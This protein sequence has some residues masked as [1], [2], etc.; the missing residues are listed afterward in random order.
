MPRC[1]FFLPDYLGVARVNLEHDFVVDVFANVLCMPRV[2]APRLRLLSTQK[3]LGGP[4]PFPH[5]T[6]VFVC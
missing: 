2:I 4:Q 1:V 6:L 3:Q 5:S